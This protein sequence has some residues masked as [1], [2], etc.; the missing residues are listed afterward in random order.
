VASS[1]ITTDTLSPGLDRLAKRFPSVCAQIIDE[2][3]QLT[4][5][6]AKT[7]APWEDQSGEARRELHTVTEHSKAEHIIFLTHGVDYGIYLETRWEGKF[8]IILPT[9]RAMTPQIMQMLSQ[10]LSRAAA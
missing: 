9:I 8:A 5:Q 2:G 4:E 3:S 1:W 10:A 6:Y 7:N